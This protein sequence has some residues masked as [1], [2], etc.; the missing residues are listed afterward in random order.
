MQQIVFIFKISSSALVQL[1][2]NF[3]SANNNQMTSMLKNTY[4]KQQNNP[5]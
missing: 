3:G 4:Q 5:F 1:N 2:K